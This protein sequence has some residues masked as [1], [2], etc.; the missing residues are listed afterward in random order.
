M[1]SP[2]SPWS[3]SVTAIIDA[4]LA[5][6]DARMARSGRSESERREVRVALR[7][8]LE[9]E[10]PADASPADAERA[11]TVL[12]PPESFGPGA[13]DDA[14]TPAVPPAP[15]AEARPRRRWGL[16]LLA[17]LLLGL[18]A[19]EAIWALRLAEREEA[20]FATE[21]LL[22]SPDTPDLPDVPDSD[23]PVMPP[24]AHPR[25]LKLREVF[26]FDYTADREVV[27]NFRFNSTPDRASL[28]SRLTLE[29]EN[30][31]GETEDLRWSFT[32]LDA[33][34]AVIIT[35]APVHGHL[36]RYLIDA[37]VEADPAATSPSAPPAEADAPAPAADIQP[38]EEAVEGTITLRNALQFQ[39][40]EAETKFMEDPVVKLDFNYLP[41][42]DKLH[43][44]LAVEPAV[45]WWPDDD[46]AGWRHTTAIRG[47]FVPGEIYTLTFRQGLP[48]ARGGA[49]TLPKELVRRVQVPEMDAGV[50]VA[51]SGHMLSPHGA[52]RIPLAGVHAD[53][54][55]V[56]LRRVYENTLAELAM[57]GYYSWWGEEHFD[58]N[59]LGPPAEADIPLPPPSGAPGDDRAAYL[60]KATLDLRALL[61]DTPP[62]GAYC[63]TIQGFSGPE[64][65][66]LSVGYEKNQ[67]LVISDLAIH[68]RYSSSPAP[69]ELLAWVN[70]LRAATPSTN[71]AVTLWSASRQVLAR[72]VTD[73]DGLA[74]LAWTPMAV[75]HR[76]ANDEPVLITATDPETG[77]LA[78]LQL[79][80]NRLDYTDDDLHPSGR[81]LPAPD[82]LQAAVWSD[83]GIYRPGDVLRLRALVRTAALDAPAEPFPVEWRLVRPDGQTA[84]TRTVTL[85]ALGFADAEF[86]LPDH[87]QTGW[88]HAY[89]RIPGSDS[90]LGDISVCLEDFLPPQIRVTATASVPAVRPGLGSL[91]FDV[92]AEYLFGAPADGLRTDSAVSF[93]PVPFAPPSYSEFVFGDS[94]RPFSTI[95]NK[96][97]TGFLDA[98]GKA[99]HPI[100]LSTSWRPPARLRATFE[101]TVLDTSGRGSTAVASAYVDPYPFY[102]G[103]RPSW[104]GFIRPAQTASVS[105]VLLRPDATPVAP[106]DSDAPPAILFTL[107]R[108]TYSTALRRNSSGRYEW[109]T[110]KTL[111]TVSEGT[112][113]PFPAENA[114]AMPAWRFAVDNPGEYLLVARDPATSASASLTLYAGSADPFWGVWSRERP[115]KIQLR[116]DAPSYAPGSEAILHVQAPFAGRALLTIETDRILHVQ[117]FDLPATTADIPIPVPDIPGLP[118]AYVSLVV[119]RPAVHE[120]IWSPHRATAIVPLSIAHPERRIGV[121]LDAPARARPGSPLAVTLRATAPADAAPDALSGAVASLFVVD[122]GICIL[123]DFKTPDPL[124]ILLAPR[125]WDLTAADYYSE[126]LPEAEPDAQSAASATPG[127]DAASL[128]RKR[129][130][131]VSA[132]R[133]KPLALAAGPI[134]LNPDGTADFTL[135]L[136]E[137]AGEIRIMATVHTATLVGATSTNTPVSRTLVV[138]PAIPRF[139]APSDQADIP[140][141]LHNTSPDHLCHVTLGASATGPLAIPAFPAPVTLPPRARTNLVIPVQALVNS[142][143]AA[144]TIT[145]GTRIVPAPDAPPAKDAP[146]PASAAETFTLVT[147]L[148]VRPAANLVAVVTNLSIPPGTAVDLPPPTGFLPESLYAT[149]LASPSPSLSL[150]SALDALETYPYGCLEQTASGAYP[151]LLAAPLLAA[152]PASPHAPGDPAAVVD[153]AIARILSMQRNGGA[154]ALWPFL[155][156]TDYDTSLY[157]LQFLLDARDAGFHVPEPPLRRAL[158]WARDNLE[159][160]LPRDN[161]RSTQFAE[162]L[163]RRATL[164][165]L[166]AQAGTPDSAWNA[167]LLQN[168][169]SLSSAARASLALALVASGDPAH[170]LDVLR[171]TTI[172]QSLAPRRPSA[173]YD[174][175]VRTTARLLLAWTRLAPDSPAIPDLLH[176]LDHSRRPSGAWPTTQDN[177]MALHAIAAYHAIRP[178][179][180]SPAFDLRLALPG[181]PDAPERTLPTDKPLSLTP[182]SPIAD[183]GIRLRNNDATSPAYALLAYE[184]VPSP[185]SPPAPPLTNELFTLTRTF[186]RPDGTP[187]DPASDPPLTSGD[188]FI[189]TLILTPSSSAA[190]AGIDLDQ[191]VIQSLLPAG[192]EIENPNLS[193]AQKLDYAPPCPA[194]PE[195][196]REARDDRLLV[197]T[198]H[199]PT[200]QP[201]CY[202][203]TLRATIPGTYVLPPA[204]AT[205]MYLPDVA[206]TTPDST[207]PRVLPAS[208]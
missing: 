102:V 208:P 42:L 80:K 202:V 158:R 99:R 193:N 38:L 103:I 195:S 27:L 156:A 56:T 60:R 1:T 39:G 52:L 62:S 179:P 197:F 72:A 132:R 16:V 33:G 134:P 3:E 184:G 137:F 74:R 24:A 116:L 190:E 160:K 113:D 77:D 6:I 206:S 25:F 172:P 58:S 159:S 43:D 37:G 36:I 164:A 129:L 75:A 121:S 29:T 199:L 76:Y 97:G 111:S 66:S 154:F 201:F 90:D 155:R 53:R 23:K 118:N 73:A 177:A 95:R 192:W 13:P 26:P 70:S 106:G 81:F 2:T 148:P 45:E 64:D 138:Q 139:L 185:D 166:L 57:D 65:D 98:D 191:I 182:E 107:Q 92:A 71:I 122:E 162:E 20:I 204:H 109:L 34:G 115:G 105:C 163:A 157:A 50:E 169:P 189:Q 178:L 136:P 85:D 86:D 153:A 63:L 187:Y 12:D 15:L 49:Q 207:T 21:T 143:K 11:L 135:D 69:S 123:T 17:L 126:L 128:L 127:G 89:L 40:L 59:L 110:S 186:S 114:N 145:A 44:F 104:E 9:A 176:A 28:V 171:Q 32:G 88:Y 10:L 117:A 173:P 8:Q 196:N 7:E 170:A 79:S 100:S 84:L 141:T 96:L 35:T 200:Y 150:I 22:N 124:S 167:R 149:L 67:L 181:D 180:A 47:K 83:R 93:S 19:A 152:L 131:P 48:S 108:V 130:S 165:A 51:T 119:V 112:L 14:G 5:D 125:A 194:G 142:G 55:H 183:G 91:S 205:P 31:D 120:A 151:Y 203:T 54:I 147:E 188:I 4:Y 87:F 101:S 175:P 46:A 94:T 198:S 41:D 168:L 30:D 78:F 140:V 146:P 144:I 82:S 18:G 133:Y 61:G 161:P 68:A 174:T